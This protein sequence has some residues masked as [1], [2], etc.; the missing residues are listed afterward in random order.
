MEIRIGIQ[1]IARELVIESDADDVEDMVHQGFNGERQVLTFV[2]S[3]GGK[4]II[5]ASKLAYVTL[6]AEH[7]RPVGFG[8]V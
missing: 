5:P 6:G 8:S 7:P 1:D 4:T 2:D 3:K